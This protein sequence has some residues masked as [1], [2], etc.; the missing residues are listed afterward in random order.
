MDYHT[1]TAALRTLNKFLPQ[2]ARTAVKAVAPGRWMLVVDEFALFTP[3]EV[4]SFLGGM[5]QTDGS[6]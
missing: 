2:K 5:L 4:F 6:S 3:Q 1:A